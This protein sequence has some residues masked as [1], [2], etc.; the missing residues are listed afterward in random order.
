LRW[1]FLGPLEIMDLAVLDVAHAVCGY[2]F[3]ALS[4]T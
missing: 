2:L 4:D 3:A 1:A